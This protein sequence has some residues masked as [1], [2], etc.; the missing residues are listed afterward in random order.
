MPSNRATI[1]A[2]LVTTLKTVTGLHNE[3]FNYHPA[4]FT[5]FPTACVIGAGHDEQ[6]IDNGRDMRLYNFDIVVYVNRSKDGFG[7]A[8][9]E[10]ARQTLE[11][12]IF[13]V[14][15]ADQTLGGSCIW[16]RPRSGGWNY[17]P[18]L[19]MLYFII[20]VTAYAAVD[21]TD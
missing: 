21:V 19:S 14:L 8:S 10:T 1:S 18:E 20:N 13:T 4:E 3:V 17:T 2:N 15:D 9:A 6:I 7:T 12:S 11:D 16:M 5:R